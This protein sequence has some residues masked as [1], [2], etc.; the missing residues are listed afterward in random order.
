MKK[1][2]LAVLVASV[3]SISSTVYADIQLFGSFSNGKQ[4]YYEITEA[5]ANKLPAWNGIGDPPLRLAKAIEISINNLKSDTGSDIVTIKSLELGQKLSNCSD[6]GCMTQI[7][8]Y[9]ISLKAALPHERVSRKD[10]KQYVI[11][12]DGSLVKGKLEDSKSL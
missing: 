10:R 9:K 3:L 12:M 8:Y 6:R 4:V 7:C 11:L 2:S 5:R 1:G